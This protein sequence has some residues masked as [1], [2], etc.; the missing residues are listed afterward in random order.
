MAQGPL[1]YLFDLEQFGIKFGLDNI[2]ALVEALG[3][4]DRAF[5]VAHIAGTN[6]KGSVTAMVDAVLRTAG[7][8]T[9]RYTSPH[10]VE[11]AERFTIGGRQVTADLLERTADTIRL[12]VDRLLATG[13]LS[14]HPTFFEATTA[15]AL[16]LFEE[17]H[18]DVAVCE[19][20]LGGRLDATNVL[21]PI[22][23][24]ITSIGHD[25]QQYLGSTLVEIAAEK[26]GII[27]EGV[28]V[29]LGA[30]PPQAAAVIE[31]IADERGAPVVHA[32]EGSSVEIAADAGGS[33]ARLRLRTP[34]RDY[35]SVSL[36]LAGAHQVG[37]ALVAT[38][39]LELLDG[40]GVSVSVDAVREGLAA[41][42]WP[43]RLDLRHLADGREA[44][45]DAAHNPEGAQALAS[46]LA[47]ES[48]EPRAL[49]FAA[50]R[51]KDVTEMLRVLAPQVRALVMTRASTPRSAAPETLMA[52]A[53]ASNVTCPVMAEPSLDL[54]LDAAWQLTPRIAIAG[55]I[56][57]LGDVMKR[58]GWS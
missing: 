4:P 39:V 51:D 12:T 23:T 47:S 3:H 26:A 16:L 5:H 52:A 7:H 27:K 44:L 54:A 18:V 55:S 22:V 50:M 2:R 17:A 58:Q 41:T 57:L 37:N 32:A 30:I 19:V 6:G 31:R 29:V 42:R 8:R 45:L 34:A 11:L 38:R 35:G 53:H 9:G 14:A 48:G 13:R 40:A 56:F 10:L 1:D 43:G 25:H 49:V 15:M 21:S 33:G 28:P 20:G 36:S 46:F 24:A